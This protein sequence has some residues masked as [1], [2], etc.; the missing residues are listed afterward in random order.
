MQDR[1]KNQL[2]VYLYKES[3]VFC[4]AK[5]YNSCNASNNSPKEFCNLTNLYFILW[6][7]MKT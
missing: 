1:I 6:K 7:K 4:A 2:K 3:L 5:E